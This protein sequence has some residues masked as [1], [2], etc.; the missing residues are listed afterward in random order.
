[1]ITTTIFPSRYVQGPNAL[2]LLGEELARLGKKVLLLQ[3]PFAAQN[4][5]KGIINISNDEFFQLMEERKIH[6]SEQIINAIK[7]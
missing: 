3:D 6:I 4:L 7:K 5:V 1:M 2:E